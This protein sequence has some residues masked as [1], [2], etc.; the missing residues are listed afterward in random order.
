LPPDTDSKEP[1]GQG[2]PHP[3]GILWIREAGIPLIE[4]S[5]EIS[6]TLGISHRLRSRFSQAIVPPPLE[7]VCRAS[8][9]AARAMPLVRT[10]SGCANRGIPFVA[11]G[12]NHA[13]K[14]VLRA[15]LVPMD[16]TLWNQLVED[17]L[18]GRLS[19]RNEPLFA[20]SK[21]SSVLRTFANR[22][23][24]LH[25]REKGHLAGCFIISSCSV[26]LFGEPLKKLMF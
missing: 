17:K 23:G 13:S 2:Q 24:E 22:G 10:I 26:R 11:R 18:E 20:A 1:G 5:K 4:I 8:S 16:S 6:T 19:N 14:G 15:P 7:W 21:P 9:Q 12:M 25:R 3:M